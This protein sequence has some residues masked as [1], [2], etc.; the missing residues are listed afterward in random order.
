M[1]AC[2]HAL[3]RLRYQLRDILRPKAVDE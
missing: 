1:I 2:I 3:R